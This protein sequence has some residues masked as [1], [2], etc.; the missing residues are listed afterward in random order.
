MHELPEKILVNVEAGEQVAVAPNSELQA[1]VEVEPG[2]AEPQDW[3]QRAVEVVVVGVCLNDS[4]SKWQRIVAGIM[5]D[6]EESAHLRN[7]TGMIA[8]TFGKLR[9]DQTTRSRE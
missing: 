2:I 3:I 6:L 9:L 8:I 5:I 1:G 4:R 7:R